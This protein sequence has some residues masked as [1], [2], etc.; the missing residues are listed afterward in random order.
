L[1]TAWRGNATAIEAAGD[2]A[3]IKALLSDP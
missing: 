3:L 1:A 2:L